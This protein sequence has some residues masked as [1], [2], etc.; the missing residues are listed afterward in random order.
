MRRLAVSYFSKADPN[1]CIGVLLLLRG[2][3]GGGREERILNLPKDD[4]LCLNNDEPNKKGTKQ[5]Q[6][7]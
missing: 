6:Q 5:Q 4:Y 2:V 3:W 1:N 7:Q